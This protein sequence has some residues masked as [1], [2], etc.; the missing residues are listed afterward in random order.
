MCSLFVFQKFS[1][2]PDRFLHDS[3]SENDVKV[4]SFYVILLL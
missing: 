3:L 2:L 1:E 4:N